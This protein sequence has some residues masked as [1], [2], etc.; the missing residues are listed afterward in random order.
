MNDRE[1]LS[2]LLEKAVRYADENYRCR[3]IDG[4]YCGLMA[5][6]LLANGVLVLPCKVGDW[7][8]FKGLEHPLRVVAVHFYAEGD[9]QISIACGKTTNTMTFRSFAEWGCVLTKE[10]AEKAPAE[11]GKK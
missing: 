3:P 8:H 4:K 7:V 1:S 10:E 2:E 11:R 9:G 5:D 6:H